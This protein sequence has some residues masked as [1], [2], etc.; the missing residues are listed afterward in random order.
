MQASNCSVIMVIP[1]IENQLA[2]AKCVDV[3]WDRYLSDSLKATARENRGA[4]I[5]QRLPSGGNGK[6]PRAICVTKPTRQ[7]FFSICQE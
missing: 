4:G 5:Q 3:I 7:S 6:F 1:F 2:T